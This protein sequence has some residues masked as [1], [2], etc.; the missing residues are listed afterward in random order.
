MHH[1]FKVYLFNFIVEGKGEFPCAMLLYDT[2]FPLTTVDASH[3]TLHNQRKVRLCMYSR[4]PGIGPNAGRWAYFGW[5]VI[6][7]EAVD[8]Y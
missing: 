4:E 8:G 7:C 1:S 3:M 5:N 2:C 6:Q